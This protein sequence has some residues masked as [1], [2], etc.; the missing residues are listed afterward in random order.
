MPSL[1]D[2]VYVS[3]RDNGFVFDKFRPEKGIDTEFYRIEP[4]SLSA[5]VGYVSMSAFIE[6]VTTLKRIM[7]VHSVS[8]KADANTDS[9]DAKSSNTPLKMTAQLRTY[10]FK[11]D[12]A[13]ASEK[14]K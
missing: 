1:V 2:S 5:D 9:V 6:E 12:A 8:F 3:A 11:E 14:K 13:A 10:I 4:I 7:N